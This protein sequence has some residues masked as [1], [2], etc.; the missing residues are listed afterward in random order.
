MGNTAHPRKAA[1]LAKL[2]RDAQGDV[3]ILTGAGISTPSGIPDFRSKGGLWEHADPSKVASLTALRTTPELFW[4]FHRQN[5]LFQAEPNRA[6]FILAEFEQAGYIKGVITQNIDG[7]HSAAGSLGV[8]EVHGN[9]RS[10]H[11]FSCGQE[12]A[13]DEL[14]DLLDDLQVPRCRCGSVIKPDVIL[15]EE[16]LP[17]AAIDQAY[18]W[19][20][21]NRLTIAIGTSLE[22][23]PVA[24]LPELTLAAGGDVA[25]ITKSRTPYH[26][27]AAVILDGDVVDEL[28]AV[29][30]ALG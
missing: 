1:R 3:T 13:H 28:E 4:E 24:A 12:Y 14:D 25:I 8:A 17:E 5:F 20:S 18:Q 10:N 6:H 7:L 2:I 21:R 30:A 11:C 27:Q 29:Q 15:F 16:M 9:T 26:P 19:C 23:H 22:V